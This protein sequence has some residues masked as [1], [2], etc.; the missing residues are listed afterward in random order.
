MFQRNKYHQMFW[1]NLNFSSFHTQANHTSSKIVSLILRKRNGAECIRIVFLSWNVIVSG[2][3]INGHFHTR[4]RTNRL[5][6]TNR[7]M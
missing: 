6:R 1:R 3:F 4:R 7:P 5:R 2:V